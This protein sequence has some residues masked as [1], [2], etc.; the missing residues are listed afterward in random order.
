MKISY[1]YNLKQCKMNAIVKKFL[2]AGDK[3]IPKIDLRQSG[4]TSKT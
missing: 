1:K 4:N 3:F 2:I